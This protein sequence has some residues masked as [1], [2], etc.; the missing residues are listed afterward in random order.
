MRMSHSQMFI[1]GINQDAGCIASTS[2]IDNV[3]PQ[4]S[5]AEVPAGLVTVFVWEK[6]AS[7]LLAGVPLSLASRVEASLLHPSGI[8]AFLQQLLP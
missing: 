2:C 3:L 8:M 1:V 7:G 5:Y 4:P 6:S